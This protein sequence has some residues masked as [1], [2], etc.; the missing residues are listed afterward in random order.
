MSNTTGRVKATRAQ[1]AASPNPVRAS[2]TQKARKAASKKPVGT[3]G[4]LMVLIGDVHYGERVNPSSVGERNEYNRLIARR[5]VSDV[6]SQ[7]VRR[8]K[9]HA[10]GRKYD[11]CIVMLVGDIVEGGIVTPESS[12]DWAPNT[13]WHAYM[14]EFGR[15]LDQELRGLR[16]ELGIPV[17]VSG[18]VGNHG[19]LK[20]KPK[21]AELLGN[22]SDRALYEYLKDLA[23]MHQQYAVDVAEGEYLPLFVNGQPYVLVHGDT[24]PVRGS[25]FE[26]ASVLESAERFRS[27]LCGKTLVTDRALKARL[28][29]VE[30]DINV[31]RGATMLFGHFHVPIDEFDRGVVCVG[32]LKG[33]DSFS[34]SANAPYQPASCKLWV[35]HPADGVTLSA[36]LVPEDA[37]TT[38][39]VRYK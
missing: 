12:L 5:R 31:F 13:G 28:E 14:R 21:R 22:N 29:Q 36:D 6:L 4:T 33:Y 30:V 15:F 35:D 9:T 1:K 2:G 37:Y 19:A 8:A 10:E 34:Q 27:E 16:I 26:K 17:T 39:R 11:Q 7:V 24:I 18:V 25:V 20:Y 3:A 23:D 32:S 38:S